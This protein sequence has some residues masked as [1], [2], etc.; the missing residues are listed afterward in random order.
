MLKIELHHIINPLGATA[1]FGET[2]GGGPSWSDEKNVY[3][4]VKN[5]Y[6]GT[7]E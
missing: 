5:T 6:R 4:Q 3:M 7:H 2:D 1:T